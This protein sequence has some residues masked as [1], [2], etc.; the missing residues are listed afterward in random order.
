MDVGFLV[1]GVGFAHQF[2]GTYNESY[3]WPI[4][5]LGPLSSRVTRPS[6]TS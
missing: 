5:H 4:R 2:T 6:L 3:F 1:R